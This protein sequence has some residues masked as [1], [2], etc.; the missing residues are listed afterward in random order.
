MGLDLIRIALQ[1]LFISSSQLFEDMYSLLGILGPAQI[2]EDFN[3][4]GFGKY[5]YYEP[6]INPSKRACIMT[7]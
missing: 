2:L 6:K 7:E 5:G 4:I 1:F 3:I